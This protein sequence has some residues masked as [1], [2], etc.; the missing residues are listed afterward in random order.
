MA[1]TIP[2]CGM[3]IHAAS[4]IKNQSTDRCIRST[5]IRLRRRDVEIAQREGDM[6]FS[7]YEREY[8]PLIEGV[9]QFNSWVG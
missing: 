2:I 7:F 3:Y 4:L 8:Y 6:K 9:T 1:F 5:D